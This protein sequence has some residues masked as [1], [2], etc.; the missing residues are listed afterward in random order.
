ML[1]RFL[2]F[3]ILLKKKSILQKFQEIKSYK[4][5]GFLLAHARN[6]FYGVGGYFYFTAVIYTNILVL[7]ILILV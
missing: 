2:F 6:V 3:L 7:N 4:Y 1:I 5:V